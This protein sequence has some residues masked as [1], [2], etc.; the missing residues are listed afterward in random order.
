MVVARREDGCGFF[1][2]LARNHRWI[3]VERFCPVCGI[4]QAQNFVSLTIVS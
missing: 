3:R 4:K 2:K 1:E